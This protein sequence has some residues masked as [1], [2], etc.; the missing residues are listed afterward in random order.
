MALYKTNENKDITQIAGNMN[1]AYTGTSLPIGAIFSSAIPQ[2][3]NKYHLLDGGCISI[4]GIYKGFY[5]LL[6][7]LVNQG[8]TITCTADEYAKA[9]SET[10]NSGRFVINMSSQELVGSYTNEDEIVTEF[11]IPAYSIKLPTITMFIQGINSITDIGHCFEAGLPNITGSLTSIMGK[12]D[13]SSTATADEINVTGSFYGA[14]SGTNTNIS[15]KSPSWW[16]QGTAKIDASRSSEVYGNSE[17]VQPQSTQYPYYIVLISGASTNI[18]ANPTITGEEQVLNS[19]NIGGV[20][21]LL[22]GG[23]TIET[24][25]DNTSDDPNI[26]WGY[27]DGIQTVVHSDP[28]VASVTISGKDFSKYKKLIITTT[29]RAP[30]RNHIL[31]DL[32]QLTSDNNYSG[33]VV[34]FIH[35]T[36]VLYGSVIICKVDESK[37]IITFESTQ[38][39]TSGY[40][41]SY[42]AIYKIEGVLKTPKLISSTQSNQ[43]I[44][45]TEETVIGT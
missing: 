16:M 21:Y 20:N 25:Y 27:K 28:N 37:S 3:S 33:L 2:T 10:G 24:I 32:T 45:S 17:T 42:D 31:V 1:M 7:S 35:R 12:K 14:M 9:L 18:Q 8:Y 6:L 39:T 36:S 4:Q 41:G 11:T 26:N 22:G 43:N 40:Y 13:S 19:I 38:Y 44:Y 15:S 29:G 34:G 30:D 5:N 23:E